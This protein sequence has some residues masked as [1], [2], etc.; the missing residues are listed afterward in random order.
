[1]HSQGVVSLSVSGSK[2]SGIWEGAEP[3]YLDIQTL[4]LMV[5]DDG[6]DFTSVSYVL[7]H[8]T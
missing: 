8:S 5:H 3:L 6:H 4:L 2:A 1:M 7:C